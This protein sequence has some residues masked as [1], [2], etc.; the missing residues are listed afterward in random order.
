MKNADYLDQ[1]GFFVGNH[2]FD[3]KD[4]LDY[5]KDVL[6]GYFQGGGG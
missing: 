4:R 2:H 6:Y 5:L 1:N 3:I